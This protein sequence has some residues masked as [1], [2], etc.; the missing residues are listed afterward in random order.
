MG[1]RNVQRPSST[2][3]GVQE[4]ISFIVILYLNVQLLH[5]PLCITY[6]TGYNIQNVLYTVN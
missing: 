3:P 6:S 1:A 2:T 5:V 4:A